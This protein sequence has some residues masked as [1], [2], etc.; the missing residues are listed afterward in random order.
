MIVGSMRHLGKT[1]T[2]MKLHATLE[3]VFS[4]FKQ[5]TV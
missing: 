5:K 2:E 4:K 1:E 3:W